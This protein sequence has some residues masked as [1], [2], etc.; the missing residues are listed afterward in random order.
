MYKTKGKQTKK[1]S[2]SYQV[3]ISCLYLISWHH[4]HGASM[5]VAILG[6]ILVHL[7]CFVAALHM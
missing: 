6:V 4:Q 2:I 1:I 3:Q 5:S 7:N